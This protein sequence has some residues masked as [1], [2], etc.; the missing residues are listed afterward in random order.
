MTIPV[1]VAVFVPHDWVKK[2]SV[3][4]VWVLPTCMRKIVRDCFLP[5]AILAV[6]FLGNNYA[7]A[8]AAS[9]AQ[10][11]KQLAILDTDIGDDIDDAFALALALQ[12][13][14]LEILGITTTYGETHVR[15]RIVDRFLAAVQRTEILVGAGAETSHPNP[16]TQAAYA[17]NSPYPSR[18]YPEAV[19]FTLKQIRQYPGQI[20]LIAIG[21]LI[22]VGAMIDKD[23]ETFRKLKR[24]VLMG[25]SIYRG[26][27]D[28]VPYRKPRGPEPEWNILRDPAS[29]QKLLNSGV[30]IFMMPLDSTQLKL[31]EVKREI[32]FRHGSPLTDQLTLLYH[33]WGQ[34][35]PTLFDPMA[36]A[37]A[38]D[39]ELCPVA[40]LRLR[41][42]EKGYTKLEPGTP[43]V[44]V[45][46]Q[47]NS[48]RFFDFLMPRLL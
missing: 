30:P 32:L 37:F 28:V 21:P 31:D 35:T 18:N 11:K 42:D 17:E 36:I 43:N 27:G 47:S 15:A 41:V 26:Y 29:A 13:P 6:S 10:S 7:H 8:Q 34:L 19:E 39:P 20:T 9:T 14:E 46:L 33:Q 24:V 5:L 40:P 22:N 44:S 16:L 25:G 4:L 2:P 1:R 45:C 38:V 48:G 12:S 23:R 3:K